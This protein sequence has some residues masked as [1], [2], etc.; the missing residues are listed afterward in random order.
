MSLDLRHDRP[1]TAPPIPL[2]GAAGRTA[3][4]ARWMGTDR[5]TRVRA[6]L[7]AAGVELTG[8]GTGRLVQEGV[9]ADV[10]LEPD[11]VIRLTARATCGGAARGLLERSGNAAGNVRF[12]RA[13]S[14]VI[15]LIAETRVDGV[16]HLPASL[17]RI[18]DSFAQLL[19]E[20]P[21]RDPDSSG[22]ERERL[23]AA[24]A[25]AGWSEEEVV[26]TPEGHELHVPQGGARTMVQAIAERGSVLVR[27]TLLP[28]LPE[29]T[30]GEAAAHQALADNARLRGCR[31]A[32]AG[33]ALVV[34]ARLC[35][36]QL[37]GDWLAYTVRAVAAA[38]QHMGPVLTLLA[39]EPAVAAE[40]AGLFLSAREGS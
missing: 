13:G 38:A 11:D 34:E 12:S 2:G 18:G 33:G 17:R 27:R 31:L 7:A 20:A 40:Y 14:S 8:P 10:L 29:G 3:E 19:G 39:R 36:E 28:D 26:D 16:A 1:L 22:D 15:R 32:V 24:V 35:A 21:V 5:T 37:D 23:R 9:D 6:A 30:A 25:E 4:I